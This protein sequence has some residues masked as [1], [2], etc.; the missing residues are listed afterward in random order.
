MPERH[1]HPGIK[2][3]KGGRETPQVEMGECNR[4]VGRGNRTRG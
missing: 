3:H 2:R 4:K 1:G